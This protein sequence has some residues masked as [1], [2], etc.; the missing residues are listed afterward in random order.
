M[1]IG[2]VADL[3]SVNRRLSEEMLIRLRKMKSQERRFHRDR[4]QRPA[5]AEPKEP[6]TKWV[7]LLDENKLENQGITPAA[8]TPEPAPSGGG[9]GGGRRRRRRR[10]GM[11]QHPALPGNRGKHLN[12]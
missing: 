7:W 4:Q 6:E 8:E 10:G 2:L 1:L 12:E 9:G 11:R 3:I 5:A